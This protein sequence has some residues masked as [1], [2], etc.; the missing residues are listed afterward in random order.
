[1][2]EVPLQV[3]PE[4]RE[5]LARGTTWKG[6]CFCGLRLGFRLVRV[7]AEIIKPNVVLLRS[8]V[9]PY[10]GTSSTKK[11]TPLGPYR[12]PMPRVLWGWAFSYEQSTPVLHELIF[13]TILKL[14]ESELVIDNLLVRIYIIIEMIRWTGLAPWEFEFPFPGGLVS[15][16]FFQVHPWPAYKLVKFGEECP[17]L[18]K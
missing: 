4:G 13:R 8:S 11:R 18:T 12:R 7:V 14:S 6:V 2:S 15:S 10:R 3:V 1:M 17:K 5:V 9:P 16:F